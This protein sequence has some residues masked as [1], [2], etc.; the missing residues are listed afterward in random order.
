MKT[1]NMIFSATI[2]FAFAT[3]NAMA[4]AKNGF[5]LNAG[6]VSH[7]MQ[8]QCPCSSYDSSGISLGMDYQIA[9]SDRFSINPFL[10]TSGEGTNYSGV[11]ANHGILGVQFR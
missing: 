1:I 6:L 2:L 10:M 5:S 8:D 3:G 9:V 4:E 11:T 7:N